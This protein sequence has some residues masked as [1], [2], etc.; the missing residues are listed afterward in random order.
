MSGESAESA[1]P[2]AETANSAKSATETATNSTHGATDTP[3]QATTHHH[4]VWDLNRI[5]RRLGLVRRLL[6]LLRR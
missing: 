2:A 3:A 6:H 1:E 4:L 5:Q